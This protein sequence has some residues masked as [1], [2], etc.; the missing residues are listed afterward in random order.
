MSCKAGAAG[1]HVCLREKIDFKSNMILFGFL[2]LELCFS[3]MQAQHYT[4]NQDFPVFFFLIFGVEFRIFMVPV[5][6]F[7]SKCIMGIS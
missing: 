4:L 1:F 2:C 3:H 5:I 6:W 7:F